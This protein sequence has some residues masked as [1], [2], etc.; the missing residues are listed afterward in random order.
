M[1]LLPAPQRRAVLAVEAARKSQLRSR[2]FAPGTKSLPK[3]PLDW[4]DVLTAKHD[5][6]PIL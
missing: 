3:V 4:K 2:I 1:K 6:L 5:K